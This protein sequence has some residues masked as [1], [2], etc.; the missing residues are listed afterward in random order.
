MRGILSVFLVLCVTLGLAQDMG[1]PPIPT[2]E[3]KKVDF[4]VGEWGGKDKMFF[5]GQESES[6]S[7]TKGEMVLGGRYIRGV[8][9]YMMAGSPPMEGMHLLTYDPEKK[10]YVAWWFDSAAPNVME[11]SGNFE[12]D[13]LVMVSKPVS[14]PGMTGEQVFRSSWWKKGDKGLMFSLELK[15]G[16]TWSKMIEGDYQKT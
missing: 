12:G 3:L 14:V 4:L 8:V 2:E 7:K 5:G 1:M 16:D 6:T 15:T 11:M 13:K 10:A 9:T